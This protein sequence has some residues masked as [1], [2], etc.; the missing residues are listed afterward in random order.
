MVVVAISAQTSHRNQSP[1][2][3]LC[4]SYRG[5]VVQHADTPYSWP[6]ATPSNGANTLTASLLLGDLSQLH[7]AVSLKGKNPRPVTIIALS[8]FV[9]TA[10]KWIS[11]KS[12]A[13]WTFPGVCSAGSTSIQTCNSKP[14]FQTRVPDMPTTQLPIIWRGYLST[15]ARYSRG[16]CFNQPVPVIL[17]IIH[18]RAS[19]ASTPTA[20]CTRG[21]SN[22]RGTM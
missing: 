4:A 8:V 12:T 22:K 13:A 14:L 19:S 18:W 1:G 21:P 3:W 2:V 11:P 15:D 16:T 5:Y 10:A 20:A 6:V 17:F 9:L 7:S